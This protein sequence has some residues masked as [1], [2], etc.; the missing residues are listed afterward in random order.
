[1]FSAA[2]PVQTGVAVDADFFGGEPFDA[3]G[4][5]EAAAR[6]GERAETIAHERPRAAF[7]GEAAVVV[8]FGIMNVA[9]MRALWRLA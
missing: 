9:P 3:A 5:T 7:F 4:E 8:R 1:M 2:V 6:T